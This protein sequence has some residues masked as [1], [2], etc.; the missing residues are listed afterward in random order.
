MRRTLTY[1]IPVS[2]EK[3]MQTI[4]V[5]KSAFL[6]GESEKMTSPS[7]FLI[8]GSIIIVFKN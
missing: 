7:E 5:S 4:A 3:V 6:S 1:D 8:T 2:E